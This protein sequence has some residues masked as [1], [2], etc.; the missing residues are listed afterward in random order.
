[1][2]ETWQ[3]QSCC[4]A[5]L[6]FALA[7]GPCPCHGQMLDP[8]SNFRQYESMPRWSVMKAKWCW[9]PVPPCS[10]LDSA[11]CPRHARHRLVPQSLHGSIGSI[12]L[13]F[14]VDILKWKWDIFRKHDL[15]QVVHTDT[16]CLLVITHRILPL[17]RLEMMMVLGGTTI[18]HCRKETLLL[19][20]S[21]E[22]WWHRK[23][24]KMWRKKTEHST[25]TCSLEMVWNLRH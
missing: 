1:M 8:K 23:S 10:R 6:L 9:P 25:C 24:K 16:A 13:K 7:A 3:R 2:I 4:I 20:P 18:R 19:P 22:T 21:Q 15:N 12:V 17:M 5:N 11:R 14:S